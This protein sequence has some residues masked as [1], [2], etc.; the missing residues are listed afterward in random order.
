MAIVKY[1]KRGDIMK[2]DDSEGFK[3]FVNKSTSKENVDIGHDK[4]MGIDAQEELNK[5]LESESNIDKKPKVDNLRKQFRKDI[6]KLMKKYQE[7][8]T[9][10]KEFNI[11]NYGDVLTLTEEVEIIDNLINNY[12]PSDFESTKDIITDKAI[13]IV[14]GNA[15]FGANQTKRG[16]IAQSL[17][18]VACG[19]ETGGT[20][21]DIMNELGLVIVNRSVYP[22]G[23]FIVSL[24]QLGKEF[25]YEAYGK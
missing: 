6:L 15:N 18:K 10:A 11:R 1:N 7:H 8:E 25:L 19:Y 9:L 24:S 14:W 23:D 13:D 2:N 21:R 3:D 5:Q 17:L 20:I 4:K 16:V 12:K 22:E